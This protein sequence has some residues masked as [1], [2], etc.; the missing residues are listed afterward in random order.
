MLHDTI[1]PLKDHDILPNTPDFTFVFFLCIDRAT[2]C[3]IRQSRVR[4]QSTWVRTSDSCPWHLLC[5]LNTLLNPFKLNL[6]AP[7]S[8]LTFPLLPRCSSSSDIVWLIEIC[9]QHSQKHSH[10][11][12]TSDVETTPTEKCRWCPGWSPPVTVSPTHW[13]E[14]IEKPGTLDIGYK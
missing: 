5:I 11:D 3:G 6:L 9:C 1:P 4:V 14:I 8:K 13:D 12:L 10:R 7:K 2:G